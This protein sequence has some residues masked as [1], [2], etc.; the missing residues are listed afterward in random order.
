MEALSWYVYETDF[1]RAEL[2]MHW[3]PTYV[4]VQVETEEF[5]WDALPA[6]ER[7]SYLGAYAFETSDPTTGGPLAV[8]L[9]VLEEDGRLVGRWGR[10]PIALVPAGPA[11]FRI[12]FL[13]DGRLFDVADEM[14]IRILTRD[15]TSTGA[16]LRWEGRVFGEGRKVG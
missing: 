16:E 1:R 6:A 10:A 5:T 2:R 8:T 15:G 11:E 13:R 3:G 4:P 7:A 12:G 14:T 9:T